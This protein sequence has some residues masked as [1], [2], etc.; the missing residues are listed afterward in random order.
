[1]EAPEQRKFVDAARGG[2]GAAWDALYRSVYPRLHAFAS[3]R[4]G[5]ELAED[6]V[7]ETMT[8]AVAGIDRYQW[9]DVGFDAWLF[10]IARRITADHYRRSARMARH[11]A[12]RLAEF[13]DGRFPN[14]EL[15]GDGIERDEEH[16]ELRRAF[17]RL[18][19][20][21]RELLQL[22]VV[23]ELSAEQTAAVLGKRAG[24]VRTA[25]SRALAHLRQ[26]LDEERGR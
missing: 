3:H 2:D 22:R 26:L 9:T 15:P 10:G 21:E 18:S 14:G 8:R 12:S 13:D 11:Q 6:I 24:A 17:D 23:G 1:M 16:A 5:R 4:V 25:Q 7:S 19:E 20:P